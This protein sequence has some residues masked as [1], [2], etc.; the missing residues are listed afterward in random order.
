MVILIISCYEKDY[1]SLPKPDIRHSIDEC[2]R[3]GKK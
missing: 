3:A 1:Y 2:T